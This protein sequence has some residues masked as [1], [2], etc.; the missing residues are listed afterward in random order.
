MSR[1]SSKES[2]CILQLGNKCQDSQKA[3][4]S[5]CSAI[6]VPVGSDCEMRYFAYIYS[7][8]IG[9]IQS[10]KEA[11][12]G[13]DRP[14]VLFSPDSKTS[15]RRENAVLRPLTRYVLTI[16]CLAS[17]ASHCLSP[18]PTSSYGPASSSENWS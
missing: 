12:D 7:Y 5:I 16:G 10:S 17:Q 14:Q 11:T 2:I 8:S 15:V 18:F 1:V 13:S 4:S 3:R 9:P 6:L